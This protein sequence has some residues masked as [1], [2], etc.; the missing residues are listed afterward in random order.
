MLIL[1]LLSCLSLC[2]LLGSKSLRKNLLVFS[3]PKV[4]T[5]RD[6]QCCK[7]IFSNRQSKNI[8]I[9]INNNSRYH[10]STYHV[11]GTVLAVHLLYSTQILE[12]G[13]YYHTNK[14]A[15]A[16]RDE[17]R[18]VTELV[19]DGMELNSV[20]LATQS[21]IKYVIFFPWI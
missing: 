6:R 10:L 15:E 2:H 18:R 4:N 13:H 9:N 1:L 14:V 20:C 7:L 12:K 21:I 5:G 11:P 17:F 16:Q 8:K 19:T 3:A